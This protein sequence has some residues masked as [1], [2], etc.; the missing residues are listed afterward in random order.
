MLHQLTAACFLY[1]L[2]HQIHSASWLRSQHAC[3]P[4]QAL[5]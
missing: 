2:L 3:M 4:M 5:R 1:Q